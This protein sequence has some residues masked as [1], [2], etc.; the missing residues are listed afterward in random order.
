MSPPFFP[1]CIRLSMMIYQYPVPIFNR[2]VQHSLYLQSLCFFLLFN[3]VVVFGSRDL[4]VRDRRTDR[5]NDRRL[6]PPRK[7]AETHK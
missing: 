5:S 1:I 7:E 6:I 3:A 2:S 4:F